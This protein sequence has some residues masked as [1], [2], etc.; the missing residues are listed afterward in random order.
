MTTPDPQP[1]LDRGDLIDALSWAEDFER[2]RWGTQYATAVLAAHD[3]RVHAEL[4]AELNGLRAY[5]ATAHGEESWPSAMAEM[6]RLRDELAAA[7]SELADTE[8]RARNLRADFAARFRAESDKSIRRRDHFDS[9]GNGSIANRNLVSHHDG[10]AY[11]MREAVAIVKAMPAPAQT[12][13]V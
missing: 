7:Q 8:E 9:T 13:L 2:G 5:A 6:Q 1:A 3:A 4:L 12:P 10:F 11:G